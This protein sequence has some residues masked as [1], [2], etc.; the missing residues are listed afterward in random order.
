MTHGELQQ[1]SIHTAFSR[2]FMPYVLDKVR[3][4]ERTSLLGFG[5]FLL[6]ISQ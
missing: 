4:F 6:A 3:A 5:S 1:I 2:E